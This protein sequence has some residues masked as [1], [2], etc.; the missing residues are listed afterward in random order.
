MEISRLTTRDGTAEPVSRDQILRHE[1]EQGNVPFPCSSDH[2]R[3]WQPYPVDPYSCYMCDYIYRVLLHWKRSMYSAHAVPGYASRCLQGTY[4]HCY[5]IE[6]AVAASSTYYLLVA[7]PLGAVPRGSWRPPYSLLLLTSSLLVDKT[8][9]S[10]D[11]C[12]SSF[13]SYYP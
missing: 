11:T 9:D 1:S 4:H 2:V 7:S 6:D 5:G 3:D 8:M 10:I 13:S 12:C